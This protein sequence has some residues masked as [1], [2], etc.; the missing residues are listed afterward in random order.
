MKFVVYRENIY[1]ISKK[2]ETIPLYYKSKMLVSLTD[3]YYNFTGLFVSKFKTLD[4]VT[5]LS[6]ANFSTKKSKN[7]NSRYWKI[8]II[9]KIKQEN[10]VKLPFLIIYLNYMLIYI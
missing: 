2:K 4:W 9:L 5:K 3:R 6:I 1:M 10:L 7:K 8:T